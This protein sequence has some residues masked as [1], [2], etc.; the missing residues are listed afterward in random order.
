MKTIIM[1]YLRR[2]ADRRIEL[3]FGTEFLRWVETRVLFPFRIPVG[4]RI[5]D[6]ECTE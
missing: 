3:L 1:G 5:T 4:V 2:G 6:K